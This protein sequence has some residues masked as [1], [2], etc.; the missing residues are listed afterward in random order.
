MH[1]KISDNAEFRTA[2]RVPGYIIMTISEKIRD[3]HTEEE[4]G[5]TGRAV[6]AAVFWTF[7]TAA[8]AAALIWFL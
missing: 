2:G 5:G 1:C 6:R 7:L 3:F 4:K 8:A